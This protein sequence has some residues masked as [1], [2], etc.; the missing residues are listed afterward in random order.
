MRMAYAWNIERTFSC[1]YQL[2]IFTIN[3]TLYLVKLALHSHELECCRAFTWVDKWLDLFHVLGLFFQ[4]PEHLSHAP[5]LYTDTN[6]LVNSISHVECNEKRYGRQL[7]GN[8]TKCTAS[9]RFFL[10]MYVL[11]PSTSQGGPS[12]TAV[13][14]KIEQSSTRGYVHCSLFCSFP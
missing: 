11:L 6:E 13:N 2:Y 9:H 8:T 14:I 12:C 7:C 10:V 1:V 4:G 3:I 5:C